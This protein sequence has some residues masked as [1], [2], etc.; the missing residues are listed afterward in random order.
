[1]KFT[2]SPPSLLSVFG[3]S[4]L[5]LLVAIGINTVHA[6]SLRER[7][8]ATM[9]KHRRQISLYREKI[10]REEA[11]KPP[12]PFSKVVPQTAEENLAD[13]R[14]ADKKTSNQQSI[15]QSGKSKVKLGACACDYMADV[16]ATKIVGSTPNCA[17]KVALCG[18]CM[19]AAWAAYWQPEQDTCQQYLMGANG[20]CKS[21]AE[22]AKA[23]KKEIGL[24]YEMYGPQF[25][26]STVWCREQGCCAGGK[27]D[28]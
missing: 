7:L 10:K 11:Y 21:I 15:S 4:G 23:A 26:A 8:P 14:F 20:V 25:G 19:N 1:M 13:I 18:F 9:I 2:G 5:L 16:S 12:R 17:P 3:V 27:E 6:G 24:L 28:Q 22:G